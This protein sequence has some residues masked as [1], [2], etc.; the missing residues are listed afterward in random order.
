MK[1]TFSQANVEQST[2]QLIVDQIEELIVTIIE[3]IRQRPSVAL[4]IVA[5]VAGAIAGSMLAARASRRH[6][7]P[8]T[9]VVKKARGIGEAAEL[10]VLG[11]KLVQNPLVRSFLRSAIQ[12]QLKKRFVR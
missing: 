12:S 7:S 6:S 10:A 9:G 11:V 5:A 3:E 4:A 8:T 2:M 1:D